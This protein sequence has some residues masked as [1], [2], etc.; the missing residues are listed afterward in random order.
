MFLDADEYFE[1]KLTLDNKKYLK[2]VISNDNIDGVRFLTHNIDKNTNKNLY[3]SYNLKFF[4]NTN[5]VS[6]KRSIHEILKIND[7]VPNTYICNDLKLIHTGYTSNINI[8]KIKRNIGILNSLDIKETIDYFYLARE[9]LGLS[10]YNECEK[11]CDLF[12]EQDDYK[13]IIKNNDIAYMIYFYKYYCLKN[14][15]SNDDVI[16]NIL[17]NMIEEIPFIPQVYYEYALYENN[18]NYYK[19]YNYYLKAIEA[20]NNFN[21][22]TCYVNMYPS[23]EPDIYFRLSYLDKILGNKNK[24]KN[25][26]IVSCLLDRE[27]IIYFNNL[28]SIMKKEPIESIIEEIYKKYR[29]SITSDYEFIIKGL[30]NTKLNAVFI[31][32]LMEYNMKYNGGN[33]LVYIGMILSNQSELAI[34]TALSIYEKSG[35]I[36]NQFMA[37]LAILYNDDMLYYKKYFDRF[38]KPYQNI[39]KFHFDNNVELSKEEY[40]EYMNLYIRMYFI[41]KENTLKFSIDYFSNEDFINLFNAYENVGDYKNIIELSNIILNSNLNNKELKCFVVDKLI[42]SLFITKKYSKLLSKYF[43]YKKYLPDE[44]INKF[45]DYLG[46]EVK[47]SLLNNAC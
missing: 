46:E 37:V 29:P 43:E 36:E 35:N 8:E 30:S 14:K 10:N 13:D 44:Y 9:N 41:G 32:F 20:N 22:D 23:F 18:I 4:K 33:K 5:D 26:A 1:E 6:Y 16:R 24:S 40:S 34:E 2:D 47:N 21:Y 25:R 15:K 12:F 27:N 7:R 31:Y 11:Y 42:T 28:L 19:A 17:D 39:L 3:N 38:E 45:F